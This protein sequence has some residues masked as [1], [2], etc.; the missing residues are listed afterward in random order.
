MSECAECPQNAKNW[1]NSPNLYLWIL[2]LKLTE[3]GQCWV[4]TWTFSTINTDSQML[5]IMILIALQ[6]V[7]KLE[8]ILL[9]D[10][11]LPSKNKYIFDIFFPFVYCLQRKMSLMKPNIFLNIKMGFVA[12]KPLQVDKLFRTQ[13]CSVEVLLTEAFLWDF[14]FI[15]CVPVKP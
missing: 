5:I 2:L 11:L 9:T 15:K 1:N 3:L 10:W 12:F 8:N 4:D 13:S 6:L 7:T 14:K